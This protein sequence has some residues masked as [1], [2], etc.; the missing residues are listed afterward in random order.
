MVTSPLRLQNR[1]AAVNAARHFKG[2]IL[3]AARSVKRKPAYVLKWYTVYKE[4]GDVQD[5][6][7]S[8]RP[9]I[10][11]TPALKAKAQS[12]L[13][14]TQSCTAAT[15][16]L[17]NLG[18]VPASTSNKTTWRAVTQGADG[19]HCAM[20]EVIPNITPAT[21]ERRIQFADHHLQKGT[22][23]CKVLAIDSC[24][25]QIGKRNRSGRVW[26]RRGRRTQRMAVNKPNSVH[27][28][29]G[30][31]AFG[32]T[33]LV[34]VSGTTG[35]KSK[36]T[37]KGKRLTG[38]GALE[39]QDALRDAL[40]PDAQ[41][42]FENA[43]DEGEGGDWQL[44]MDKA[45]AHT[46]RSTQ[47]WLVKEEVRVVEKWPGNSPDLNPIENVWGWMKKRINKKGI[48]TLHQ[49]NDAIDDAWAAVPDTSLTKL[50]VGMQKRLKLVKEKCG[51]YIGK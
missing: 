1:H 29:G 25:F 20:E 43:N 13:L 8:G 46:A 16:Q 18:L 6:P 33:R 27:V 15:A 37:H 36:Y 7:R 42:I 47:Q 5:K 28:Y 50:M 48:R 40:V 19:L 44:L 30:V 14:E 22:E 32:K 41:G 49:L 3:A 23:W 2:N 9:S 51:E 11:S 12:L 45:P 24:V 17:V 38:V 35:I 31:S 39:F 26:M 10:F 34:R 21:Q 4:T